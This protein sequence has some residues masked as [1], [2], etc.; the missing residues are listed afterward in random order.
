VSDLVTG[1]GVVLE[2]RAAKLPS[3][4]IAFGIDL[5]VMCPVVVAVLIL[6]FNAAADD[7]WLTGAAA[8]AGYV[9][10]FVGYPVTME[11]LT[12]GR[13]LGKM[14]LGLRV[15]RQDGGPIRFRHALARGLAGLIVDF[16][17]FSASTGV[18]AVIVS[19]LSKQGRRVGDMLAGTLVVRERQSVPRSTMLEMPPPLADWAESVQLSGLSDALALQVRQFLSRVDQLDP[20]YRHALGHKLAGQIA[21][22]VSPPPPYGTPPEAYLTAVLVMRRRREEIRLA[23]ARQQQAP[24]SPSPSQ[25]ATPPTDTNTTAGGFVLPR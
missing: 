13:T 16:G 8:L 15:V 11:T 9:G 7:P 25:E 10:V 5:L 21:A 22:V 4:A 1:D 12:R 17:G 2:L 20:E 19:L 3:R 14:A 6:A 18:V 24:P 23:A